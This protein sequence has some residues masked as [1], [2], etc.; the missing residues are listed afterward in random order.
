MKP[1]VEVPL[2]GFDGGLSLQISKLQ[3]FIACQLRKPAN[4]SWRSFYLLATDHWPLTTAVQHS[5]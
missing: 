1:P 4:R 5:L 3:H 2:N